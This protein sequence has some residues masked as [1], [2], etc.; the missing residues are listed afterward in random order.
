M[1]KSAWSRAGFWERYS[2]DMLGGTLEQ[3]YVFLAAVYGGMICGAIYS[4]LRI[5]RHVTRKRWVYITADA[6]FGVMAFIVM[7]VVLFA[8]TEFYIRAYF[9]MGVV[10]GF[11]IFILGITP[12]FGAIGK[13]LGGKCKKRGQPVD[14]K[15]K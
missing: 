5:I 12:L 10:V 1:K 4:I 14:N 11:G 3:P 7:S 9:F 13:L 2:S 6:C 8:A 15:E